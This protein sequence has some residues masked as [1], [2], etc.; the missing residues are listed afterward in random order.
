[1]KNTD[2]QREFKIYITTRLW[3]LELKYRLSR[4][5]WLQFIFFGGLV[6]KGD[7]TCNW[8]HPFSPTDHKNINRKTTVCL[9]SVPEEHK[10]CLSAEYRNWGEDT[11]LLLAQPVIQTFLL[12][13]LTRLTV[14]S[15]TEQKHLHKHTPMYTKLCTQWEI[16]LMM[17]HCFVYFS[18]EFHMNWLTGEQKDKSKEGEEKMKV[19]Q[20]SEFASS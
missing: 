1:M 15:H 4:A 9:P 10:Y 16:Q 3:I 2:G 7:M 6:W 18:L 5:L 20:S 17:Q 12:Q 19:S 11:T 8:S 13:V 14:G